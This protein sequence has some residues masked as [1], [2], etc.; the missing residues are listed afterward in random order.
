[1]CELYEVDPD[2][3]LLLILPSPEEAFAPWNEPEDVETLP[4]L[5]ESGP[6]VGIISSPSATDE[7]DL[8]VSYT[9]PSSFH[10]KVSSKH[11]IL[12]SHRFK[13]MLTGNWVEAN[14]VYEDGCRHVTLEGFDPTALKLLL[15]IIHG[16][17]R[18]V[19]RSLD[20]EMLAK[21]SVIVD[22]LECHEEVEVF[23]EIWL[24]HLPKS[25]P[26][27]YN[28]DLVLWILISFVF[29]QS[30]EFESAT[31]TAILRS[32][33]PIQ[34]LGLPLRSIIVG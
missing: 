10:L 8:P 14:L 29:R 18:K 26:T 7:G 4:D 34:T 6:G 3:D 16:K 28:R 30:S 20:L 13:K 32:A 12:A 25:P 21:V 27:E 22:D 31:R 33:G 5:P 9:S 19:P 23:S 24:K 15:D 17:T 11:L 1:M 2:G